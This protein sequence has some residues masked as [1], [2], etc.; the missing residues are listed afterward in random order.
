MAE[1]RK[2]KYISIGKEMIICY[3][4]KEA[5]PDVVIVNSGECLITRRTK[6]VID[7]MIRF[8]SRERKYIKEVD[9]EIKGNLFVYT[10]YFINP[11]LE[12]RKINMMKP[13]CQKRMFCMSL[14]IKNRMKH[15]ICFLM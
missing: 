10:L 11:T 5:M 15:V 14:R 2:S 9:A 1:R 12:A 6:R 7:N 8:F 3:Q 13:Y 4:N